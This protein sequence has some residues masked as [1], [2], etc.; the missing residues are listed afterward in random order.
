LFLLSLSLSLSFSPPSHHRSLTDLSS[1]FLFSLYKVI[2][3]EADKLPEEMPGE[4]PFLVAAGEIAGISGI[5]TQ[6]YTI[7]EL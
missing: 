4:E 6:T 2:Q 1:L 5:E 7:A 3:F